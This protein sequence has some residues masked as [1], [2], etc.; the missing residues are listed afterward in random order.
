MAAYFSRARV[1]LCIPF[2]IG[3]LLS[4]CAHDPR[5]LDRSYALHLLQKAAGPTPIMY[6]S[7]MDFAV[8]PANSGDL[9][10]PPP[11]FKVFDLGLNDKSFFRA[12]YL[13][14]VYKC[15]SRAE[16][17]LTDAV[18][19]EKGKHAIAHWPLGATSTKPP[20]LN[21]YDV[22]IATLQIDTVTGIR[23]TA[24]S[25]ASVEYTY[26]LV[27]TALAQE[28]IANGMRKTTPFGNGTPIG[29]PLEGTARFVLYDDGWRLATPKPQAADE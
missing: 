7:K 25:E 28:L 21:Q 14:H 27:P 18:V 13:R 12:G 22:P 20:I 24:Q 11:N 2:F 16:G 26:T 29:A 10:T 9:D 4:A 1:C 8:V 5:V 3:M 6:A 17:C 15:Y 19:T 23:K